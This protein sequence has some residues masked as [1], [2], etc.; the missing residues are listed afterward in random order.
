MQSHGQ[1]ITMDNH[2]QSYQESRARATPRKP[3]ETV[4]LSP[5]V[6]RR[7]Y[8]IDVYMHSGTTLN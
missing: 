8:Q 3:G 6:P 4:L 5:L 7:T 1:E 2:S